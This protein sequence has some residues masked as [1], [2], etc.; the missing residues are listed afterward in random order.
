MTCDLIS[1][2][3]HHEATPTIVT[4]L[5]GKPVPVTYINDIDRTVRRNG[6]YIRIDLVH[7][8]C[9]YLAHVRGRKS[10]TH[11][12]VFP[13]L[14]VIIVRRRHSSQSGAYAPSL[15]ARHSYLA[16]FLQLHDR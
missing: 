2:D 7:S 9:S 11:A 14:S 3:M 4:E 15:L 8:A 13:T 12:A 6:C 10:V 5:V 1:N 16:T